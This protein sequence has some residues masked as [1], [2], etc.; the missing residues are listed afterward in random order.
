ML[1]NKNKTSIVELKLREQ[2]KAK[3]LTG[4]WK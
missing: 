4:K 2:W 1:K 3:K